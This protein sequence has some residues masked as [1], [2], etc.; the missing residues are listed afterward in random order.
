MHRREAG[1]TADHGPDGFGDRKYSA[2]RHAKSPKNG[3]LPFQ[4]PIGP[5]AWGMSPLC[6]GPC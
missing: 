6:F 3:P 5:V 1:A 4:L 2:S